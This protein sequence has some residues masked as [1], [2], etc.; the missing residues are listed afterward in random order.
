MGQFLPFTKQVLKN[1]FSDDSKAKHH[2][3]RRI[4]KLVGVTSERKCRCHTSGLE[5]R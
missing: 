2:S 4:I 3:E 5:E 1:L